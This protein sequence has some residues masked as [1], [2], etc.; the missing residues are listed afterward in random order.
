MQLNYCCCC[1]V[2]AQ[3]TIDRLTDNSLHVLAIGLRDRPTDLRPRTDLYIGFY[4]VLDSI[5]NASARLHPCMVASAQIAKLAISNSYSYRYMLSQLTFITMH[6]C[7]ANKIILFSY[8]AQ[9][10][11]DN[12]LVHV[13]TQLPK[14]LQRAIYM[15]I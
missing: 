3:P 14:H 11:Y 6:H 5:L 7:P 13:T 2:S 10:A 4:L 9:D 12:P 15:Y 1:F 8:K